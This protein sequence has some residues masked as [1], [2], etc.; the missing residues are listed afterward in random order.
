VPAGRNG[1]AIAGLVLGI[2]PVFAGLL[3]VV[4]GLIGRSQARRTGQRGATMGTVGALLGTA[5]L[6]LVVV[7]AVVGVAGS[8]DRG[9]DGSVVQAG[10]E[11]AFALAVGDCVASV[12]SG[13]EVMDLPLVPCAESHDGEVY[14]SF[15]LPSGSFPGDAEVTLLA[16]EGCYERFEGFVGL[17]YEVS[18]LELYFLQPTQRSWTFSRDRAV[19]CMVTGDGDV[20]SARGSKR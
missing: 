13:E 18:E 10:D 6:L 11:S 16:E 14:A 7:A 9:S 5:W 3:G 12:P 17:A 1:F 4:F 2:I 8:P 19:T 15:E 20:G